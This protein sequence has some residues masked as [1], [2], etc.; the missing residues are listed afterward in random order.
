MTKEE[1]LDWLCRLRSFLVTVGM[2]KEW[3]VNFTQAL[4]EEIKALEQEPKI[5]QFAKWV[6]E[7]IFDENWEYNK[8]AFAEL[9]CRKLTKL[10]IVRANGDEWELVEPQ[11]SEDKCKNCEYYRNP[12]YTRCHECEAESEG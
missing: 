6:A 5:S 10:G 2:P 8:D 3:R 12:D 1:K 7:E 4:S 9:V 11:E